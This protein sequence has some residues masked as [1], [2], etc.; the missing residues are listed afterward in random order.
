MI[1][2]IIMT[3]DDA[4]KMVDAYKATPLHDGGEKSRNAM[5]L[6]LDS[7]SAAKQDTQLAVVELLQKEKMVFALREIGVAA[8]DE[9]VGRKVIDALLEIEAKGAVDAIARRSPNGIGLYAFDSLATRGWK[10][11]LPVAGAG[12]AARNAE[13]SKRIF[14]QRQAVPLKQ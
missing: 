2:G 8:K 7:F 1:W 4:K 5:V 11:D 6:L 14:A 9:A 3:L 10:F 12:A 13:V